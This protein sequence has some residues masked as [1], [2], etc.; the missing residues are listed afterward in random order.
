MYRGAKC[1]DLSDLVLELLNQTTTEATTAM[2]DPE[3]WADACSV[4]GISPK[5]NAQ[6]MDDEIKE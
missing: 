5:S 3:R 2:H 1:Q 6:N 4:A